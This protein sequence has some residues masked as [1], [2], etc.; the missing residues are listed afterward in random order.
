MHDYPLA[1]KLK[2]G[3]PAYPQKSSSGVENPSPHPVSNVAFANPL[4]S[5]RL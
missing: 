4:V 1:S 5:L 2:G 3:M